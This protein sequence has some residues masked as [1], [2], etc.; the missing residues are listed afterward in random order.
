MP[1]VDFGS[2]ENTFSARVTN[3]G[4]TST[5]TSQSGNFIAS[6]ARTGSNGGITVNFTSGMFSVAPSVIVTCDGAAG[7]RFASVSAIST[8]ACT[9]NAD[10]DAGANPDQNM[11]LTVTRQGSDYRQTPQPTAAVIKPAVAL[12]QDVKASNTASGEATVTGWRT[13]DL[14]TIKG[15]SWFIKNFSSNAFTLEPGMYEILATAPFYKCENIQLRLYDVTNSV[16]TAYGQVQYARSANYGSV[17]TNVNTVKTITAETQYRLEY[18]VGAT[19]ATNGLGAGEQA[20]G[21]VMVFA[22]VLIR[23]L[24]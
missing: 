21:G 1:L 19:S 3:N 6:V 13:R 4:S 11:N 9:I 14:N 24:K 10:E 23:K 7:N 18:Q 12:L 5:I 15:E 8:T 17:T 16:A 22:Q 20:W 2:F